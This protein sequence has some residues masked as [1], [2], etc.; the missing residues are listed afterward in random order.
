VT[1]NTTQAEAGSAV[2]EEAVQ[3]TRSSSE[4]SA[5]AFP[6]DTLPPRVKDFVEECAKS[7][8][9]PPDL[10][11]L[12]ALVTVG[13]AIGNSR[14]VTLKDGWDESASIYGAIVADV[15]AM[16]SPALA[17]AVEP[18]QRGES[19]SRRT[20]T[21]DTTVERLGELLAENPRGLLNVRDELA[22][23]VKSMNQYKGGRGADRQFY[24]SAWSSA[25]INVDRKGGMVG[26]SRIQVPR[27]FLSV[28]GCL[29]PD[30]LPQLLEPNGQQ[31]GFIERLLFAWPESVPVRWTD[32]VITPATRKAYEELIATL[33][34]LEEARQ[35]KSTPL[36][37]RLTREAQARFEEWVNSHG[38]E[39]D[40]PSL[41]PALKVFYAKLRGYCARL[42]LIHA[43]ATDP[44]AKEIG[45]TSVLAAAAQVDNFK[46]QASKVAD[47]LC[48]F[49]GVG[50]PIERCKE[51]IRRKLRGGQ[52]LKKR[53]IQR[54][55]NYDRKVFLQAFEALR[56]PE[57]IEELDGTYHLRTDKPTTDT[58]DNGRGGKE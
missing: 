30:V 31:D 27:P 17:K 5:G 48:R 23:W 49:V 55:T 18:L 42:A 7:L 37:L 39:M 58:T 36:Q 47:R 56:R 24:L 32:D 2:V 51:A 50:T 22:A 25:P 41:S 40:S 54:C 28:I 19:H 9:V 13:A 33:L 46:A 21:S 11:A 44:Q 57:L 53:E 8:P 34:T 1:S 43:L 38:Q 12:P 6:T 3:A 10:I 20:W 14:I 15:G 26:S 35:D 52:R 29:P 4:D 16:K 45:E